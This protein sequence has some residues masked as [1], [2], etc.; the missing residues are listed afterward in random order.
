MSEK[1]GLADAVLAWRK[2]LDDT[3]IHTDDAIR[4]RY[5]RTTHPHGTTPS[6][7]LYPK[8]VQEIQ[9]VLKIANRYAV[10]VYPVS[11]GKNWGYGDAC[12]PCDDAAILD[13]SQMNRILRVDA[14]MGYAVLEPG[15]T[16]QQ[17]YEAVQ[18]KAPDFWMDSSGAGTSA[19][20]LGNVLERGFGHTPY[21]DHVRNTC[22]MEV[23]LADGTCVR[24]G[25][26]HFPD[27]HSAPLYPYGVGPIL[28]GLF[29]QSNFAIVTQMTV[30]LY[31]APKDFQLF[32]LKQD[33]P[34]KLP[35]LIDALRPLRMRGV[36]NSAVHIGNDLRIIS[37]MQ[38]YPWEEAQGQTPLPEILRE[39]LR[40]ANG[41]GAWNL[42][43]SLAGERAQVRA[44]SREVRRALAGLGKLV[45]VDDKKLRWGKRAAALLGK[46]GAAKTLRRQ[47]EVLE[48]N[49]GLLK[50]IPT[51]APLLG[52]QWRL[53]DLPSSGESDPLALGCGLMWLSPVLPM[54]GVDAQRLLD[55]VMPVFANYGF[56][57]PA[58][59]TLLNE[60]AMVA[61]LN[62]FY[63]KK[64]QEESAAAQACYE[65]TL[66]KL[67]EIGYPPYRTSPH[68]MP[69]LWGKGDTFWQ[70]T[71][72][73]KAALDP[74]DIV[75]RG[76]Y[77]PPLNKS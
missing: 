52:T 12:A 33:D 70:T 9:D 19:S 62:V 3:R 76:R 42:S 74:N 23:V 30:W 6:C 11:C 75:A 63:D 72:R 40:R 65:E 71:Q 77:I 31:P 17:L 48:P 56:E 41:V 29:M 51:D 59:F 67:C 26:G 25:F 32:F 64:S 60:R 58:T 2:V 5:A 45:F 69:Y 37:S 13:L 49:Y 14:E 61:I 35:E 15:V 34:Q 8:T 36:L 68:G 4:A 38:R 50:G 54:R 27:A 7:V 44:A 47:L 16:Q 22:G 39:K 21:G 1:V 24:T 10:V 55:C 28:D 66:R 20:V 53:R 18:Q 43:A 46:L 73:I 57:L